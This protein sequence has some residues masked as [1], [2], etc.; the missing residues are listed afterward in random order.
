[1]PDSSL[2]FFL[3]ILIRAI[4]SGG[5]TT[6]GA[7]RD[8]RASGAG[9]DGQLRAHTGEMTWAVWIIVL[10]QSHFVGNSRANE[11]M[12]VIV[13]PKILTAMRTVA[14]ASVTRL[15][16]ATATN[17][18]ILKASHQWAGLAYFQAHVPEPF[19]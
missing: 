15:K 17:A 4:R 11:T 5:E 3:V 8:F 19:G 2:G 13:T 16:K 12:T 10:V 1:M 7:S 9:T 6:T 14:N 18:P